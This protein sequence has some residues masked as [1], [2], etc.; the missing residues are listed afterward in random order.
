MEQLLKDVNYVII[1]LMKRFK[2]KLSF[3]PGLLIGFLCGLIFIYV[4][5]L[6]GWKPL[7]K[8]D[9]IKQE[10]DYLI[11]DHFF[12]YTAQDFSEAIMGKAK[13]EKSLVVMSQELEIPTT[14]T[15]AGLGNFEIFSKAKTITY[16]GTG[17]YSVD[18]NSLNS[19]SIEVDNE[20]N[21]VKVYIPHAKFDYVNIDLD[22]TV[23]EDTE[24]G[25]LAFGDIAL[26]L[27]QQNQIQKNV[28]EMMKEKLLE[29]K[30]L[31]QADEYAVMKVWELFQ[32]L[33]SKTAPAYKLQVLFK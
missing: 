5:A 30:Y 3:I 20:E 12:T 14:I 6:R 8:I 1:L 9:S 27:E 17:I 23:F 25:L 15:K 29:D 13:Q 11:S 26:T 16:F 24:K 32:P 18:L 10:V 33:I 19:N 28:E 31:K 22:K 4:S 7:Q 2:F 21:I